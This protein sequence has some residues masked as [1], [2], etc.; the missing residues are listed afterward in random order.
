[1]L[2]LLLSGE[3]YTVVCAEDGQAAVDTASSD[4][5]LYILDDT[6]RYSDRY[7]KRSRR[8][9]CVGD[10]RCVQKKP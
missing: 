2:T 6:F 5:D 9:R 3:G 4:V 7:R 10:I 1:M 8:D